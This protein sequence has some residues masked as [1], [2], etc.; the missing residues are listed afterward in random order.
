M[1]V[2][3]A[4]RFVFRWV[5]IAS[6][7]AFASC[8]CQAPGFCFLARCSC[9]FMF[10]VNTWLFCCVCFY[11][12]CVLLNLYLHIK[13]FFE[14]V[15]F[16]E[17]L[18]MIFLTGAQLLR[19]F[20]TFCLHFVQLQLQSCPQFTIGH[21]LRLQKQRNNIITLFSSFILRNNCRFLR[22]LWA[23]SCSLVKTC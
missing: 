23:Q 5:F 3:H 19:Q 10:S 7:C 17:E 22:S 9:V 13:L 4:P 20:I 16:V 15:V 14:G 18:S 12:L 8:F 21:C 11:V 6:P 2:I 1:S